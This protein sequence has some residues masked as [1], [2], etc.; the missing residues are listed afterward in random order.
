MVQGH[1]FLNS[2]AQASATS[3]ADY[4]RSFNLLA[5]RGLWGRKT[6][7]LWHLDAFVIVRIISM[8]LYLR[9]FRGKNSDISL[10]V[11]SL[12]ESGT[13]LLCG[14]RCMK[15]MTAPISFE[16]RSEVM[17][18]LK[19]RLPVFPHNYFKGREREQ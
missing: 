1:S 5:F 12:G 14:L 4:V 15:H 10:F 18:R 19:A 11:S 13:P 8:R 17:S 9:Q 6:C 16:D 2:T 3:Q 7:A